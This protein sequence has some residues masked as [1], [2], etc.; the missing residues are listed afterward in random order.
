MPILMIL[1]DQ[2]GKGFLQEQKQ[3]LQVHGFK[4]KLVTCNLNYS[5]WVALNVDNYDI[6]MSLFLLNFFKNICNLML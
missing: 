1:E 4:F 6:N 5:R 2:N 3:L